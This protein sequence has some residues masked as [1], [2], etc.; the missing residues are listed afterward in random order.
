MYKVDQLP[1]RREG[2]YWVKELYI[3]SYIAARTMELNNYK[4]CNITT[5][6][7]LCTNYVID[8]QENIKKDT[9]GTLSAGYEPNW[10][11]MVAYIRGPVID[12]ESSSYGQKQMKCPRNKANEDHIYINRID[13]LPQ[14]IWK[15]EK[16]NGYKIVSTNLSSNYLKSILRGE[17]KLQR[18]DKKIEIA[19]MNSQDLYE[20]EALSKIYANFD[21]KELN[22]LASHRDW[23]KSQHCLK[24]ICKEWS[25]QFGKVLNIMGRRSKDELINTLDLKLCADFSEQIEIK[26]NFIVNGVPECLKKIDKVLL[27]KINDGYEQ[28]LLSDIRKNMYERAPRQDDGKSDDYFNQIRFMYKIYRSE[29]CP[30]TRMLLELAMSENEKLGVSCKYDID[31]MQSLIDKI[32]TAKI[33]IIFNNLEVDEIS[34]EQ[35][36]EYIRNRYQYLKSKQKIFWCSDRYSDYQI[37]ESLLEIGDGREKNWN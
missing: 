29:I 12:Q 31:K 16:Q 9:L 3:M 17:I 28:A 30:L 24:Y 18:R 35:D 21:L 23:K 11:G 32:P 36:F 7:K 25:R 37:K 5:F 6:T 8:W 26:T 13:K 19:K 34:M 33:P 2:R 1:S 20:L 10:F 27:D 15:V 14:S 22:I 4:N